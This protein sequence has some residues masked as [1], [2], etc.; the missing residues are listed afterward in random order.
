MG[1]RRSA[2]LV[3]AAVTILTGVLS[4]GMASART[5]PIGP[6]QHFIGLVN[7]HSAKAT[8]LMACFPPI[9]PVQTGHPL[10]G[11]TM[12]VEL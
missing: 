6:G 11:Q 4:G 9:S 5:T 1:R 3:V 10:G 12:A 7:K 8:I 2:L